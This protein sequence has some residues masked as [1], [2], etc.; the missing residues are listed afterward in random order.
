[1]STTGIQCVLI[2]NM[3]VVH[4]TSPPTVI[5]YHAH[6]KNRIWQFISANPPICPFLD[7]ERKPPNLD[8]THENTR[9]TRESPYTQ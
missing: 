3:R 7:S 4:Q 9:R 8:E 6:I 5:R 1:M 2:S